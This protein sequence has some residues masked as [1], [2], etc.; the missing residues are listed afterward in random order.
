MITFKNVRKEIIECVKKIPGNRLL[1]ETDAPFL[2]PEPE[3]GNKNEPAFVKYILEKISEIKN[4]DIKYLENL[5][6][7]NTK[8]FF[9][10][11]Y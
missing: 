5:V 2:S 8:D 7:Q 1:I 9:Q 6:N 11:I 4:I 10:G 3:R